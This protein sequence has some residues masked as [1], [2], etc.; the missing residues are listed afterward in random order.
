MEPL[1]DLSAF[2]DWDGYTPLTK[3]YVEP[4]KVELANVDV[5]VSVRNSSTHPP[6]TYGNGKRDTSKA[7]KT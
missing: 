7:S 1:G 4:T 5:E 2:D 6:L 3:G